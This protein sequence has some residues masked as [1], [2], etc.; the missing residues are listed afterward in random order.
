MG[1]CHS[2]LVDSGDEAAGPV[3]QER[4][5]DWQEGSR[6]VSEEIIRIMRRLGEIERE[7]FRCRPDLAH[8]LRNII[9]QLGDLDVEIEYFHSE[10]EY[11]QSDSD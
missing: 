2:G 3:L 4:P 1:A 11:F 9:E 6:M 7:L 8:R 10:S 5:R